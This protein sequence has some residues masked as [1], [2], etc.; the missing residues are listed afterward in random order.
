MKAARLVE[1]KKPLHL[2]DIPPPKLRTG[3]DVIVKIAGAGI[4]HTDLA[5]IDGALPDLLG[6]MPELPLIMGHENAG[7][8]YK[9]GDGVV[10]F[11][12]GDPVLVYGGWGCGTCEF[13]R[14]GEEQRCRISPMLPG[15]NKEYPGGFAEFLRVP[16]Y[17]Y[18]LKVEGDPTDLAPLADA[19][20][21][22]Y[23]AAK[24]VQRYLVPGSY[25]LVIGV[26]GLG[27]YALQY[28]NLLGNSSVIVTDLV[29]SKL[30]FARKHGASFA[31]KPGE[32]FSSQI[33]S[34]TNG[35][36]VRAVLDFVGTDES[37]ELAMKVLS[38]DAIYVDIGLGGG[39]LKIPLMDL[40]HGESVITGNIWGTFSELKE[41]YEL[42]RAGAIKNIVRRKKL[43]EINDAI[44]QMRKGE[45]PG[46]IVVVPSS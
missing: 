26:G 29:E 4:C 11:K 3:A 28:L 22:P 8:V 44:S 14:R 43:D 21:T 12:V 17:K 15:A 42:S 32:D 41:V 34:F 27:F 33:D 40:I 45:I 6:N 5:T 24:R 37:A 39:S 18:L 30:E 31:L 19:G 25:S 7:Y 46:R 36:K 13:C 1:Y 9:I 38:E 20:L 23:R 35:H 16:S 10:G 2:D